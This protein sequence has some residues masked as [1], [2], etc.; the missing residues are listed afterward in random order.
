MIEQILHVDS[1]QEKMILEHT[2]RTETDGVGISDEVS[3]RS[4]RQPGRGRGL[5][6]SFQRSAHQIKLRLHRCHAL[7]LDVENAAIVLRE[8]FDFSEA[9]LKRLGR[10][11]QRR[12]DCAALATLTREQKW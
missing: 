8:S 11:L 7:E 2:D 10:L 5:A 12:P 3:Q 9:T 6:E 1:G 4:R